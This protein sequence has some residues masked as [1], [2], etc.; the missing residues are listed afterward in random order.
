MRTVKEL[1]R[2]VGIPERT[3]RHWCE[4]GYIK[5]V[6][7]GR[8]WKIPEIEARRLVKAAHVARLCVPLSYLLLFTFEE[9]EELERL[10]EEAEEELKKERE[11]TS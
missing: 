1:A 8:A 3:L 9:L 10:R 5:A 7:V 6:K 11:K 4:K 2:E